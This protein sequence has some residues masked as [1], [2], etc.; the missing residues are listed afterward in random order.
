M[1]YIGSH[2]DQGAAFADLVLPGCTFMEKS[3]TYT[4]AEG[5]IQLAHKIVDPPGYAK[6]DWEVFRAISEFS[7]V[8][9]PYNS[10]EELRLRMAKLGPHLLKYDHVESTL[11]GKFAGR[12]LGAGKVMATPLQD[13]LDNYYMSDAVTRASIVMA[14]CSLAYNE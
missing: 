10:L 1:I 7:G 13:L 4:N 5:R 9:L 8:T 2:G 6:E 3:G 12:S 14:K 11:F